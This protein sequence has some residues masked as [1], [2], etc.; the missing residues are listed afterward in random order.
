MTTDT[1]TTRETGRTADETALKA[2]LE[3]RVAATKARDARRFLEPCAPDIVRFD[4]APPL[5]SK[6][7]ETRDREALEAWYATWDGAIEITLTEV[8]FTVGDEVA[9]SHGIN[10]MRGTKSDGSQVELWSRGTVGFRKT[11]GTWS[12]TH[13]HDSVPFLMDGSGLAALDLTP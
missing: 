8:E 2:L 6:G 13:T 7:A 5:Q 3:E 4:L 12:I 10:R 11:D 9:F 1:G